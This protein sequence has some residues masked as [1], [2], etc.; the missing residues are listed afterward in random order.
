[1]S[2]SQ[3]VAMGLYRALSRPFPRSYV[4]KVFAVVCLAFTCPVAAIGLYALQVGLPQ[5]DRTLAAVAIAGATAGLVLALIALRDLLDPVF[6]VAGALDRWGRTGQMH[7]LP[8]GYRDELGVLMVRTNRLMARAQRALDQSRREADTDPLNG[9]LSRRG[10]ERL[11]RDAPP[12][13]LILFDLDQF[14][15]IADHAGPAEGDRTLRDVVQVCAH[16]L[17]QDDVLA[18]FDG[19]V[20]LLFLPGAPRDVARRVAARIA[21]QLADKVI[22]RGLTLTASMGLA[23]HAGG[24]AID[25]ALEIAAAELSR[26]REEGGDRALGADAQDA[27]A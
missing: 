9:A 17:R 15:H 8:E 10:A 20:F 22:L 25:D 27:A 13:W 2:V 21:Q 6:T 5:L 1:M 11:L 3:Q 12:G 7:V 24:E 26:A 23:A 19:Q 4:A 16:V 18:R 14:E